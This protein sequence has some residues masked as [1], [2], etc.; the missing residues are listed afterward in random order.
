MVNEQR[1][2][3]PE[4][5]TGYGNLYNDANIVD[6]AEEHY[7]TALKL[8]PD[9][10]LRINTLVLFLI[11]HDRNVDESE[12]LAKRSLQIMPDN[13]NALYAQGLVKLKQGKY[14]E[15]LNILEQAYAKSEV[16]SPPLYNDIKKVKMAIAIRKNN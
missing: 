15:A 3:A 7:R 9:N 12:E 8:D 5:E 1:W 10:Y 6:K 16:W 11:H 13:K 2:P 14:E 4:I